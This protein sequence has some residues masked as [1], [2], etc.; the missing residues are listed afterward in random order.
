[1]IR[2]T[3]GFTWGT[4]GVS[5]NIWVGIPLRELLL[6]AEVSKKNVVGKH[7]K[8]IRHEVL[9]NKVGLGTWIF[10]RQALWEVC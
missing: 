1:M 5:T 3:I 2:Q 8:F 7:V 4:S 6:K 9:P 10:E